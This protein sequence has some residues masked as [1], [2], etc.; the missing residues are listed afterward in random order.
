LIILVKPKFYFK[1]NLVSPHSPNLTLHYQHF[2]LLYSVLSLTFLLSV[3]VTPFFI[4][5]VLSL[6][7]TVCLSNHFYIRDRILYFVNTFFS[8][9]TQLQLLE[10]ESP[11]EVWVVCW[12]SLY[13]VLLFDFFFLFNYYILVRVGLKLSSVVIKI[14]Y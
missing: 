5:S 11:R 10:V 14:E 6:F 1:L 13:F 4:L 8:V 9:L 7:V 3:F 12:T 2:L